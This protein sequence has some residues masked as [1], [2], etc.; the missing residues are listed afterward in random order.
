[1]FKVKQCLSKNSVYHFEKLC[2]SLDK[3]SF[4]I[5][6]SAINSVYRWYGLPY[7]FHW[8]HSHKYYSNLKTLDTIGNCQRLAFLLG[9]SQHIHKI[10]NLWKFELDWSSKLREIKFVENYSALSKTTSLQREPFLTMFYTINLCPLLVTKWGFMLIIILR[11]Y[12]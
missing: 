3:H 7:V 2:L 1:M 5:N 9:V 6:R 12:Q 4:S 8:V 11:N 10:T